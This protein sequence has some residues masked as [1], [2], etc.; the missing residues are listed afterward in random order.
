MP[1]MMVR[2]IP[3]LLLK[4]PSWSL[5]TPVSTLTQQ[6]YAWLIF[7]SIV[8]SLAPPQLS[9]AQAS[10]TFAQSLLSRA[11][12]QIYLAS[13]TSCIDS[14]SLAVPFLE[15]AHYYSNWRPRHV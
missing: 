2:F 1:L 5:D 10:S 8:I 3:N 15:S 6:N 4:D 11:Q 7:G 9:R 12:T 13:G 14:I